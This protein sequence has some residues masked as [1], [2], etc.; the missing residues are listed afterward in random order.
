MTNISMSLVGALYNM[1]LL[2]LFG[3]DGVAAYGV[4]MY[5]G[6]VFAAVFIGYSQGT[7][8]I[9]SYHFGAANKDEL[10]NLLRKSAGIIAVAGVAMLTSSE[11]L[12][13]PLAKIFVGY[14]AGLLALTTHGMKL[15]C[16]SFILSGF[17]ISARRSSRR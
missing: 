15:Y 1:Q 12:A 7:A 6:F 10:K 3:A 14:D 17:N 4:L 2:K 16:I 8:P 13:E 5:V 9:V 11:L